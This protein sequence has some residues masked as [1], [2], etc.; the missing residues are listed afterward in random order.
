[1]F[2]KLY[3]KMPKM[4]FLDNFELKQL[5]DRSFSF[6]NSFTATKESIIIYCINC[7]MKN[8]QYADELKKKKTAYNRNCTKRFLGL[9]FLAFLSRIFSET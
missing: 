9:L 6:T 3:S 7:F 5:K 2:I 4:A 1:M 8:I